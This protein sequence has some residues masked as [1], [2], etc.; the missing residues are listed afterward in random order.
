MLKEEKPYIRTGAIAGITTFFTMSY[1]EEIHPAMY[2]LALIS[3]GLLPLEH[4]KFS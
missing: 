4:G 3:A 1:S 2:E